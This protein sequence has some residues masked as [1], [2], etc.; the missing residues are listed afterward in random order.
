MAADDLEALLP[1]VHEWDNLEI[2]SGQLV[3]SKLTPNYQIN[4]PSVAKE[5][6]ARDAHSPQN[7][8]EYSH[9]GGSAGI[10]PSLPRRPSLDDLKT[11]LFDDVIIQRFA[12]VIVAQVLTKRTTDLQHSIN[13]DE[14]E[15]LRASVISYLVAEFWLQQAKKLL[16]L[17]TD[18]TKVGELEVFIND[19]ATAFIITKES[20]RRTVLNR[21]AEKWRPRLISVSPQQ[22]SVKRKKPSIVSLDDGDERPPVSTRS[23]IYWDGV[24]DE[25]TVAQLVDK[26]EDKLVSSQQEVQPAAGEVEGVTVSFANNWKVAGQFDSDKQLDFKRDYPMLVALLWDKQR[27]LSGDIV[28]Q[29]VTHAYGD[30]INQV[31]INYTL[32][33]ND[34]LET[35]HVIISDNEVSQFATQWQKRHEPGRPV[36]YW[37][38]YANWQINNEAEFAIPDPREII[39]RLNKY[40]RYAINE[41]KLR[42]RRTRTNRSTLYNKL[43]SA[44]QSENALKIFKE[45]EEVA[46]LI[47]QETHMAGHS[48]LR[49]IA[50]VTLTAI[51][52]VDE[53]D[54]KDNSKQSKSKNVYANEFN[55]LRDLYRYKRSHQT[56]R[57]R[58]LITHKDRLGEN[59]QCLQAIKAVEGI[60]SGNGNRLKHLKK[61]AAIKNNIEQ[62]T[63]KKE[64]SKLWQYINRYTV[65]VQQD[66]ASVLDAS[67]NKYNIGDDNDCCD[68]LNET[69][70][71]AVLKY[72]DVDSSDELMLL[73]ADNTQ[74]Q[75]VS[76]I[77]TFLQSC[78]DDNGHIF[79]GTLKFYTLFLAA[80]AEDAEYTEATDLLKLLSV[81]IKLRKGQWRSVVEDLQAA[82][83]LYVEQDN[84]YYIKL[85]VQINAFV[86]REIE[87]STDSPTKATELFTQLISNGFVDIYLRQIREAQVGA[88]PSPTLVELHSN[89]AKNVLAKTDA[90]VA[91]MADDK[92]QY[93]QHEFPS[94]LHEIIHSPGVVAAHNAVTED[95]KSSA[96]SLNTHIET[97]VNNYIQW[98]ILTTQVP[99]L[100]SIVQGIA[101]IEFDGVQYPAWQ[102]IEDTLRGTLI[103]VLSGGYDT[104]EIQTT[105]VDGFCHSLERIA[106]HMKAV[107]EKDER[108][109]VASSRFDELTQGKDCEALQGAL[110]QLIRN[111]LLGLLKNPE[112]F[113]S[114]FVEI[115]KNGP[116]INI[117]KPGSSLQGEYGG[118]N[119][120]KWALLKYA[121]Q[122]TEDEFLTFLQQNW[123]QESFP[124]LIHYDDF[125]TSYQ[126]ANPKLV[127]LDTY[128]KLLAG[129]K[130]LAEGRFGIDLPV[131]EP[132][133]WQAA[134]FLSTEQIDKLKRAIDALESKPMVSAYELYTLQ[135]FMQRA[136]YWRDNKFSV[137]EDAGLEEPDAVVLRKYSRYSLIAIKISDY[138]AAVESQDESINE[139][140]DRAINVVKSLSDLADS[141]I[142]RYV[143]ADE[144][145]Y[146]LHRIVTVVSNRLEC[147]SGILPEVRDQLIKLIKAIPDDAHGVK[148]YLL[149]LLELQ[150]NYD[151]AKQSAS[152][153]TPAHFELINHIQSAN[154]D[155]AVIITLLEQNACWKKNEDPLSQL[156]NKYGEENLA[157]ALKNIANYADDDHYEKFRILLENQYKKDF[158]ARKPWIMKRLIM[159]YKYAYCY[160]PSQREQLGLISDYPNNL[161]S[162]V[163]QEI[164]YAQ[165]I[166]RKTLQAK[167]T[168]L[169]GE[170]SS[171]SAMDHLER[172]NDILMSHGEMTE[173][174]TARI[175]HQLLY[176]YLANRRFRHADVRYVNRV[177]K[178]IERLAPAYGTTVAETESNVKARRKAE[179]QLPLKTTSVVP[180][181]LFLDELDSNVEQSIE[182]AYGLSP[183]AWVTWRDVMVANNWSDMSEI[184]AIPE[185]F[186]E[187]VDKIENA[188]ETSD[189]FHC[190]VRLHL[191]LHQLINAESVSE[192]QAAV[193]VFQEGYDKYIPVIKLYLDCEGE[194]F[195]HELSTEVNKYLAYYNE[196]QSLAVNVDESYIHLLVKERQLID[197]LLLDPESVINDLNLLWSIPGY[198]PS[199]FGEFYR[200]L[201]LDVHEKI[202][203]SLVKAD[204]VLVPFAAVSALLELMDE[205]GSE[206]YPLIIEHYLHYVHHSTSFTDACE[207]SSAFG[208]SQL[209]TL[210]SDPK[211]KLSPIANAL[212]QKF[213]AELDAL[214]VD[215]ACESLQQFLLK[216]APFEGM[217]DFIVDHAT[218]MTK[219]QL[220]KLARE[221]FR[222]LQ[223]GSSED[224]T[225]TLRRNFR[226]L[227][228]IDKHFAAEDFEQ[229]RH[230][231]DS[232]IVG[233]YL[234]PVQR[235]LDRQYWDGLSDSPVFCD[236]VSQEDYEHYLKSHGLDSIGSHLAELVNILHA[237]GESFH[238][239]VLHE[240]LA[241][242]HQQF[243]HD[244]PFY[245]WYL[246]S[247]VQGDG[248]GFDDFLQHKTAGNQAP[249]PR[250]QN[251][252]EAAEYLA[253]VFKVTTADGEG[254]AGRELKVAYR[255]LS[256]ELAGIESTIEEKQ[257]EVDSLKEKIS[258]IRKRTNANFYAQEVL[259]KCL[260]LFET[261]PEETK[262]LV[263]SVLK[264]QLKSLGATDNEVTLIRTVI[265]ANNNDRPELDDKALNELFDL[266]DSYNNQFKTAITDIT[267]K[268]LAIDFRKELELYVPGIFI[269]T[270]VKALGDLDQLNDYGMTWKKIAK[271]VLCQRIANR[272]LYDMASQATAVNSANKSQE[273]SSRENRERS[274]SSTENQL[275]KIIAGIEVLLYSLSDAR[276]S[277]VEKATL[278]INSYF[279]ALS[280]VVSSE[281]MLA[282]ESSYANTTGL[283]ASLDKAQCVNKGVNEHLSEDEKKLKTLQQELIKLQKM[284]ERVYREQIL[285]LHITNI[286]RAVVCLNEYA[287]GLFA[288]PTSVDKF[289]T[290]EFKMLREKFITEAQLSGG[291]YGSF[292][293]EQLTELAYVI[294]MAGSQQGANSDPRLAGFTPQQLRYIAE[295]CTSIRDYNAHL[296]NEA[297][298]QSEPGA[299]QYH[300]VTFRKGR[301]HRSSVFDSPSKPKSSQ[302]SSVASRQDISHFGHSSSYA[303]GFTQ[304][305]RSRGANRRLLGLTCEAGDVTEHKLSS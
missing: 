206:Y 199:V 216:E 125:I 29:Q 107:I 17:A 144:L 94:V 170:D 56:S 151:F 34:D 280:S 42:K 193:S 148:Y 52:N 32:K 260:D 150:P 224:F 279:K 6:A 188:Q 88:E 108:V 101:I 171:E 253:S 305:E 141:N 46:H 112:Y 196:I 31:R 138:F 102:S 62:T 248:V 229:R 54:N 292:I 287:P 203:A 110:R 90:L 250:K 214:D 164:A 190:T 155:I 82:A 140:F 124:G 268:Q 254:R 91:T 79:P 233:A 192:I 294:E 235:Y 143:I 33:R 73:F 266:V 97:G 242:F 25:K 258:S 298:R 119:D 85:L 51:C 40:S 132:A 95:Y 200:D 180:L 58:R 117:T 68:E 75:D 183:I 159:L 145:I 185:A 210:V 71:L 27:Q 147:E 274:L 87:F 154:D 36:H 105:L 65:R 174:R 157:Q 133:A 285:P 257:H 282:V 195:V 50:E 11:A 225:D 72:W 61:L 231:I 115:Y 236:A 189:L 161:S 201:W 137:L 261:K 247:T 111:Y 35:C 259:R 255:D 300:S 38:Q 129:C 9:N 103:E 37:S 160:S 212:L 12:N 69:A 166:L 290:D 16:E 165:P 100:W 13:E 264:Q 204:G 249:T 131:S 198:E 228:T 297:E 106:Y 136:Q 76:K 238:R 84:Q 109:A 104:E 252:R 135:S 3:G 126:S 83:Q 149:G 168:W 57:F 215:V 4:L 113:Q 197:R 60:V 128:R 223:S 179:L 221:K 243:D 15:A 86:D 211:L 127:I 123:W 245:Y 5:L 217:L 220:Q 92:V 53:K 152:L 93:E 116:F 288:D 158:M 1:E 291:K 142:E 120:I 14:R 139:K 230:D 246:A 207:N 303:P 286:L 10:A 156:C 226:I 98:L 7:S 78:L 277:F 239:I 41:R 263:G 272:Q 48:Q 49:E 213:I 191:A 186:K 182:S 64:G 269:N 22:P 289:V 302:T 278:Q 162:D 118:E 293:L 99:Q 227:W 270:L 153:G 26:F 47:S 55:L 89:F 251:A 181:L 59:G 134:H 20:S 237:M 262:G 167:S 194:S 187:I 301:E 283:L 222:C 281:V 21:E 271:H 163:T 244:V 267:L 39:T 121:D 122:L 295:F 80:K 232:L 70:L 43:H 67:S 96:T 2:P 202:K 240:T 8:T 234:Q 146:I 265:D 205:R 175:K 273:N 114:N 63:T 275:Q 172:A 219:Q 44:A 66:N 45:N 208:I 284:P 276:T 18:P 30:Q 299:G 176:L 173:E 218:T 256:T 178:T 184:F 28:I 81:K 23:T 19:I 304:P 24:D 241:N 130:Q 296:T 177:K 77:C 74:K 209:A 169:N